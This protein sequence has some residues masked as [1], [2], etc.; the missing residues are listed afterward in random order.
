MLGVAKA[1]RDAIPHAVILDQYSNPNNPL[2]HYY[3]TY[4]EI[5]VSMT[6]LSLAQL[7]VLTKVARTQDIQPQ[8][9]R[10]RRPVCWCRN[11][12]DHHWSVTR[13]A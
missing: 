12:R 10:Y 9:E 13:N 5:M 6:P 1:L 3:S 7:L 2:A 4:G 8:T 11:G